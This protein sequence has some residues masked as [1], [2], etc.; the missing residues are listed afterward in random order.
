ML[1]YAQIY[2]QLEQKSERELVG[3]HN[4]YC[5]ATNNMAACIYDNT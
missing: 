3:I 5:S 2:S 1:T 4:A